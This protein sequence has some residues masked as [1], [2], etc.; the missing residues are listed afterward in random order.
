CPP[1]CRGR[2][3]VD[4]DT[5]KKLLAREGALFVALVFVGFVVLPLCIYLVGSAMF[6]AYDDG[7]LVAFFGALQ[8]ELRAGEPA[9][10]FLLFSPWLL[11]QLL[12]L[13]LLAFRRLA[14]PRPE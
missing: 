10:A 6:G 1:R 8:S 4:R 9:V 11:W 2:G 14:P 13:T 3:L 7:G 12:R 5:L